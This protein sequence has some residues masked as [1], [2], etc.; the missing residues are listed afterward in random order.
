MLKSLVELAISGRARRRLRNAHALLR[1]SPFLDF[2]PPGHF[3]SPIPSLE[4]IQRDDA[5][6]FG[7][8]PRTLPG[9]DL[10][11][12]GQLRLLEEFRRYYQD[13]P[14]RA[15]KTPGLRYF[16]ENPAYSYS[17]GIFLHCMIRHLRPRK[18]IEVGS[19]YSS[20]MMLDTNEV[21]F[22]NAISMTFIEPFPRLLSSLLTSADTNRITVIPKRL[23]D[24]PLHEFEALG[25]NDIL[26]VDSTHVGK[27]HSDVNRMFFEILPHLAAGVHV[28]FHDIFYPFEYP[29]EW[30]YAGRAWNE[31]YMLRAFL[32]YNSAFRII[33][34]NTYLEHFHRPRFEEEMPLCLKNTGGSVWIRKERRGSVEG[35]ARG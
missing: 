31:A 15:Q 35:E 14:F 2:A 4:D 26:F 23:Q 30:I 25:E 11:E 20:C 1:N 10:D 13:L 7:S 33:F 19:G 12:P 32:E 6:I 27:I 28:H 24:V 17:D 8:V 3:Y 16:F 5:V 34:M 21:F 29:R 22:G 9:V 18:I